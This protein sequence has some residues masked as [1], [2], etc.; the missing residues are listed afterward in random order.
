MEMHRRYNVE[1]NRFIPIMIMENGI[2][3]D[4][5]ILRPSYLIEHL[6]AMRKAMDNGVPVQSYIFWTISDNWVILYF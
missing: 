6:L 5:D 3:D 2:S 1:R 4:T